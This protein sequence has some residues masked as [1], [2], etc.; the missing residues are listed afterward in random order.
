MDGLLD[1]LAALED[2][3]RELSL[4]IIDPSVIADADAYKAAMRDYKELDGLVQQIR[5]YRQ[6]EV[7]LEEARQDTRSE[8]AELRQMAVEEVAG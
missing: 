5:Q 3:H 8:D 1:R 7:A 4:R 2:R 6:V